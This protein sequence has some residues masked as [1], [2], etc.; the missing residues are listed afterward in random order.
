[1]VAFG[2]LPKNDLFAQLDALSSSLCSGICFRTTQNVPSPRIYSLL[3][4]IKWLM[5]L[6]PSEAM[7]GVLHAGVTSMVQVIHWRRYRVAVT[8]Q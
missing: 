6:L 3:S 4:A 2:S 1:M 7:P 5:I 8:R